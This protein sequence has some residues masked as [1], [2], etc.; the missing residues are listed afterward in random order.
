M[1]LIT[2]ELADEKK[3]LKAH[4]LTA[5]STCIAGLVRDAMLSERFIF[6]FVLR[7][8]KMKSINHL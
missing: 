7:G 3:Q 4:E 2:W 8:L 5:H 1:G 6:S